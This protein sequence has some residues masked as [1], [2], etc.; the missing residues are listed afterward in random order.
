LVAKIS[1][2]Q[3]ILVQLNFSAYPVQAS[4]GV[5]GRKWALLVLMKI[6]LAQAKRFNQLLRTTRG[7]SKRILAMRLNELERDGFIHRAEQTRT[8]TTWALTQKGADVLPVLLTLIHFG[9]KWRSPTG[10]AG[11]S[12][13]LMGRTFDVSYTLGPTS[14]RRKM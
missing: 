11:D 1:R 10:A 13:D 9:S 3:R 12:T 7:M 2:R 6:A 4:L 14:R 5:L 8:Q